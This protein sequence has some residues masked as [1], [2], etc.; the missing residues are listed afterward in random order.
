MS[1]EAELTI[2]E[3]GGTSYVMKMIPTTAAINI[4]KKLETQG[5]SSEVIFEVIN[6]GATIGSAT[7][8]IKKFD[9]HFAGKLKYATE[10]FAEILKHNDLFPEA[11]GEAGN[12]DGS[13]E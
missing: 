12:E 9:K 11:E 6:K 8:D 13:E 3:V 4:V 10:L 2:K 7:I 5:F 1:N